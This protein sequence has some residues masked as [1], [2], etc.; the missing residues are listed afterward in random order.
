VSDDS[1]IVGL[2]VDSNELEI[3]QEALTGAKDI[4]ERSFKALTLLKRGD[5]WCEMAIGN[6]M[7]HDHSEGC[8]IAQELFAPATPDQLRNIDELRELR[9][10]L[11]ADSKPPE[12]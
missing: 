5:C 7:I 3:I 9:S 12:V 10:K 6:P 8:K 11:L 4:M 2:S 1:E